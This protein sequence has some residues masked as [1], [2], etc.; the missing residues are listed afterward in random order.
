VTPLL[1]LPESDSGPFVL[2][3]QERLH[4][5]ALR[6]FD[7]VWIC[8]HFHGY[9][10]RADPFLESWT[11]LTWLAA[12]YPDVRVGHQVLALS[13]R[14]PALVAKM[15]ATLQ[16]LSGG[17]LILGFGAGYREE[18]YRATATSSRRRRLVSS[19]SRR[20][21]RSAASCGPRRA[22]ASPAGTSRSRTRTASPLRPAGADPGVGQASPPARGRS[23][24]PTFGTPN[25]KYGIDAFRRRRDIVRR[26]AN[27][28]GRD[29]NAMS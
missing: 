10:R 3:Q 1:G 17:R 9:A 5:E 27:A 16:T 12:P 6:S 2:Y 4:D 15:A 29:P 22:P 25:T 14:N 28:F 24:A 13:H 20:R 8:D 26:S 21:C 23:V 19:S 18:E 7:S 11:T